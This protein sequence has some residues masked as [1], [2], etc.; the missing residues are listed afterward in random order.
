MSSWSV[1]FACVVVYA[2]AQRPR[3]LGARAGFPLPQE[4]TTRACGGGGQLLAPCLSSAERPGQCIVQ[5]GARR[6][7][8][9]ASHSGGVCARRARVCW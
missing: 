5:P 4:G 8:P 1:H 7:D 9:A 2:E 6:A 3:G